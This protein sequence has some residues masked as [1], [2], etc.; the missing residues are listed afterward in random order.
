MKD[1]EEYG[2]D[3]QMISLTTPSVE[4][5]PVRGRCLGKEGE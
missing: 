1:L 4:L 5:I 2:I 3:L